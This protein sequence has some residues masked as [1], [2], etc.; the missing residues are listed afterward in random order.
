MN[1]SLYFNSIVFNRLRSYNDLKMNILFDPLVSYRCGLSFP[2]G[3][4]VNHFRLAA[5]FYFIL[6]IKPFK[7]RFVFYVWAIIIQ[8]TFL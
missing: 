4:N 7:K 3:H 1:I 6:L 8:Y 2:H 5:F